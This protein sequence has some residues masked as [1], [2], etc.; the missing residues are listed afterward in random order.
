MRSAEASACAK[1]ILIGEH[2][3]VHGRPGIAVPLPSLRASARLSAGNPRGEGVRVEARDLGREGYPDE[4]PSLFP[5]AQAARLAFDRM[6]L[7]SPALTLRIES[8]IPVSRGLGSGAAVAAATARACAAFAGGAMTAEAV[9][10]VAFEVEK[11]HHGTPSGIDNATVAFERPVWFTRADGAVPLDARPFVLVL[12]DSGARAKTADMVR[13][14]ARK[15]ES[16]RREAVAILD[17]LGSLASRSREALASG[18]LAELGAAMDEAHRLLGDLGVSAPAL[19]ALVRA[20]KEA[21][22]LGAKLS[23]AGG[24]GYLLALA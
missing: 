20:A 7:P 13:I 3:V 8:A 11:L 22:A 6:G 4:D 23:G 14:V 16:D 1:A 5:L 18:G 21:G 19:D 2:A 10:A 15:L 17:R 12:A 9:S 24:G